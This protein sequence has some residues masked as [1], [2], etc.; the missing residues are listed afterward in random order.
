MGALGDVE[1]DLVNVELHRFGVGEGKRQAGTNATRRA[2][3]AK[4]IGAL[5][6]LIGGLDRPRATPGPLANQAVLLA[7]TC[8]ILKPDLDGLPTSYSADMSLERARKVFLNAAITSPSCFGWRG[9]ALTCEKPS[10]F[11][12]LPIVRSW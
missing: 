6:P 8:F 9:R 10:T 7:D 5:V 2:D 12:S 3:R 1:G 11:K 4:Q